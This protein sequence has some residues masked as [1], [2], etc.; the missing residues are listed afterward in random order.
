ME[1]EIDDWPEEP[2]RMD[3][4]RDWLSR[5]EKVYL[6]VLRGAA[7]IVAT[8]ILAWIVWL[9]VSSAYR[10]SQDASAVEVEPVEITAAEVVDID[11]GELEA[12]VVE[13]D[14][15]KPN[16][17]AFDNFAEQ[18]HQ[19][20]RE[21]FEAFAHKDDDKLSK[22]E[23]VELYLAGMSGSMEDEMEVG[24][25]PSLDEADY[26][27][28][29]AMM[30]EVSTLPASIE[31]LEKY[32][33]S[34]K[35]RR[36]EKVRKTRRE[37]YCSYYSSYFDECYSYDYRSVPYTD[38]I[39]RM[40]PPKGVLTYQQ[41]FAAYQDN[42]LGT[43]SARRQENS[44]DAMAERERRMAANAEGWSGLGNAVWFAGL[45]LALMFFFLLIAIERHQRRIANL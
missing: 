10:I 28:L 18:Y 33:D 9:L 8:V 12:P 42:Y 29:L 11:L 44:S 38:T 1:I 26:D 23:F 32:R 20:F 4:F 17:T 39:V 31:R 34:P 21:K 2:T 35:V 25:G 14:A 27:G 37:R 24:F 43:L 6:E 41:L 36:E 45:F 19:L 3:R 13:G 7:L 5:T 22:D 16:V 15:L 40:E 30:R